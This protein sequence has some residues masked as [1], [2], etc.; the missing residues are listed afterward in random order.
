L[1]YDGIQQ[2]YSKKPEQACLQMDAKWNHLL[3][4]FVVFITKGHN[5]VSQLI[6]S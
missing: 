3:T 5:N 1:S 2:S 6:L 4:I